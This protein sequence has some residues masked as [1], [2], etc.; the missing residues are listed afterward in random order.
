MEHKYTHGKRY[1]D[2]ELR[3]KAICTID[4][5]EKGQQHAAELVMTMSHITRLHPQIVVEKIRELAN[6][7]L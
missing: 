6:I 2:E 7:Q 3:A 1:H 5:L 4:A